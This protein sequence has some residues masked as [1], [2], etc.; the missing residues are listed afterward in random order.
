[1][2]NKKTEQSQKEKL[3]QKLKEDCG[4]LMIGS[5]QNGCNLGCCDFKIK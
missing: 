3:R 1:M 2:K 4:R 5:S